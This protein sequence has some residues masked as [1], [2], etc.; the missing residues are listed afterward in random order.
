M[1]RGPWGS[2]ARQAAYCNNCGEEQTS[3]GLSI[4]PF[5]IRRG[6]SAIAQKRSLCDA[7]KKMFEK[8]PHTSLT[9]IVGVR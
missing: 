1:S 8:D 3:K 6:S 5:E 9:P 7:C 4:T 2:K